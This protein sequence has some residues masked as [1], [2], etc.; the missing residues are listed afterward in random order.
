MEFPSRLV[1]WSCPRLVS[2]SSGCPKIL[3]RL[4][5]LLWH[6][7]VQ[8]LRHYATSQKVARSRP[9]KVNEL[10]SVYLILLASLDP[11]VCSASNRNE[12]QK[13][14]NNNVSGE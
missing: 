7:V 14:K 13:Q 3:E 12:Y 5:I 8:W 11:G 10:N 9:D 1:L 6:A 2:L 4:V